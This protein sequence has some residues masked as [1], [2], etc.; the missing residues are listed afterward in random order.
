MMVQHGSEHLVDI[1]E[2]TLSLGCTGLAKIVG[3][4]QISD[5]DS[6]CRDLYSQ[7]AGLRRAIRANPVL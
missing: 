6:D 3:Q 2:L 7:K 1:L 5:G 4:V